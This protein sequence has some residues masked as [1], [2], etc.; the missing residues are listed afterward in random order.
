MQYKHNLIV[1]YLNFLLKVS[2]SKEV[3]KL[4]DLEFKLFLIARNPATSHNPRLANYNLTAIYDQLLNVL[5][6]L[7]TLHSKKFLP[8]SVDSHHHGAEKLHF[9]KINVGL[10]MRSYEKYV[11]RYL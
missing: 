1:C 4:H 8:F 3:C 5:L 6:Q 10:P 9:A 11:C 2:T 7:L